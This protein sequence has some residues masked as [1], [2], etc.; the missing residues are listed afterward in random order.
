M[1]LGVNCGQIVSDLLAVHSPSASTV[2]LFPFHCLSVSVLSR[3]G[4]FFFAMNFAIPPLL[5]ASNNWG[6]F[7]FFASWCFVAIIYT[8]LM[9]PETRSLSVEELDELFKGPWFNA[10]KRTSTKRLSISD[11]E[12]LEHARLAS[13]SDTEDRANLN[14][15]RDSTSKAFDD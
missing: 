5:K 10:Y 14:R 7:I 1:F 12:H 8:F 6:A 15:T 2:S 4:L 11:A 13:R 3:K 9:V